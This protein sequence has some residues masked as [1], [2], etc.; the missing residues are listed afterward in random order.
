MDSLEM[1]IETLQYNIRN[2]IKYINSGGCI[3][4]A[5]YFSKRLKELGIAH[6]VLFTDWCRIDITKHCSDGAAH[7]MIYLE[8]IGY[9][10]GMKTGWSKNSDERYY[11]CVNTTL[12]KLNMLRNKQMWNTCYDKSQNRLVEKLINTYIYGY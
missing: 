10:D 11:R 3:H 5:Y 6:K 1:Q 2:R 8:S 12:R 9:V 4:F 7:V